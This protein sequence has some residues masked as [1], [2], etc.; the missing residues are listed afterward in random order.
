MRNGTLLL[1]LVV[2]AGLVPLA[3]DETWRC[4]DACENNAACGTGVDMEECMR[5]CDGLVFS[6]SCIEAIASATCEELKSEAEN[7]PIT[8]TCFP[9][10]EHNAQVCR[11]DKL[12]VCQD[13][14]SYY[15]KCTFVCEQGGSTYAGHCGNSFEGW[16]TE[17]GTDICWCH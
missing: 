5:N 4:E 16:Y 6:Q 7:D 9:P 1:A 10:C 3:C 17:T 13:G 2:L 8:K 15:K 14:L 12:W 11:G